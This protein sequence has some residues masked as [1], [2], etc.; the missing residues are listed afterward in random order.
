M[1]STELIESAAKLRKARDWFWIM[2][3][4]CFLLRYSTHTQDDISIRDKIQK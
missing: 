1:C 4:R 2:T 3:K